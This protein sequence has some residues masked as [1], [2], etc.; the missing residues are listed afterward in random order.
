MN[1]DIERYSILYFLD[2]GRSF[3]GA[4][5]TLLH[6]AILAK[7]AGHNVILFFSNYYGLEMCEEYKEV[8][9]SLKIEYEWSTYQITSQPEDIDVVCL[10]KNY[11]KLK[12]MVTLY[13]PD[14]L[15]SVQ[16]NPCVELISRELGIPH[17]M[18]IYPL[19]PDFFSIPYMN[20]FPHYHI[21]DSLFWARKWQKYLH[22]DS[23]C[24][25]TVVNETNA[26]S[27]KFTSHLLRFICVGSIYKEKNQLAVIMAFHEAL[28]L[29]I[30]GRLTLCGYVQGDYGRECVHYIEKNGLQNDIVIKGF[31]T[32]MNYEYIQ[33]DVLIC[34]STRESY[35]NVISEAMANGLVVISTPVAGV[36]EI[37]VDG[38]NGYLTRDYSIDALCEKIVQMCA[39]VQD[40]RV[41][42]VVSETKE[43][44]LKNHSPQA[45]VKQLIQYY[46]YV[47]NDYKYCRNLKCNGEL[48]KID[49][50]RT[51]FSSLLE[52]FYQIRD[53]LSE[54]DKVALKLWYLYHIQGV[55]KD[56]FVRKSVFYIWG[57][58]KYGIV[59]KE[60]V[61][62]FMTEIHIAGFLDSHK[63]GNFQDA[64]YITRMRYCKK[65]IQ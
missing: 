52:K 33:S 46:E 63:T 6:Q 34:G 3:G 9:Q 45:V 38:K 12:D 2:Y 43:T 57:T 58:G 65:K 44:F 30:R 51:S 13:Q 49:T 56:A 25:R 16:I 19:I 24:I 5:N 29:G 36:P 41:G 15:H 42:K 22:T 37:I 48:I 11:E 23:V 27:D 50:I 60:I 4:V 8:C 55:L 64:Q 18:N 28:R 53:N 21:C 61:E 20:I 59:V 54:P 17:I 7:Q 39:D 47:I 1:K 26:G 31:C 35:P 10:N 40:G 32:D 62:T 14:L